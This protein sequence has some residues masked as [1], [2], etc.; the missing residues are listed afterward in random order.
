[1]AVWSRE[2][3][4]STNAELACVALGHRR[5]K[6]Y[7]LY[8]SGTQAQA[9]DHVGNIESA[10]EATHLSVVDAALCKRRLGKYG[11]SKGWSQSRLRTRSGL[12][13]DAVGLDAFGRGAKLENQ[14]PDFIILDDIDK[15]HDSELIVQ[16]KITTLTKKILPS[17]SPDLAILAVQNL[18]HA[19]S[20][21]ARLLDGRAEFLTG[22]VMSG[23]IPAIKELTYVKPTEGRIKITG[24]TPTWKNLD[25][26]RCE[27]L[28]Y[29]IGLTAFLAEYQHDKSAQQ[30]AFFADLWAESVLVLEPFVVPRSWPIYRSFDYGYAKPFSVGWWARADGDVSPTGHRQYPKGTLFRIHEWYGWNGK[31]NQGARLNAE[32]IADKI[33]DIENR[34]P[35]LQ[36]RVRPGPADS[37]IWDGPPNN[38]IATQMSS[39]K[40]FWYPVDKG[41][42]SR[43]NGARLFRE[44]MTASNKTPM[45]QAGVFF[46][47]TCDQIIRCLPQLPR[48]PAD[49]DDVFTD[50]EDHNYDE[51]RYM[52]QWK[53]VP[54]RST[55]T[56]GMY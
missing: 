48:D 53:P 34:T 56:V 20:I 38:N 4:K 7:I 1:V 49:P 42:G 17:G 22:A 39:H 23:P 32:D 5:I 50:A 19:N 45:T 13:I 3:G 28:I 2:T 54:V 12:T 9:N 21:F 27:D 52:M 25:V 33:V 35:V 6:R 47:R 55:P 11:Q 10:L 40:V 44:L 30:G 36:R 43:V 41:P 8:I 26:K 24:G 46:F 15:D 14:R 16:K 29:D 31:P 18:V 37:S 51:A